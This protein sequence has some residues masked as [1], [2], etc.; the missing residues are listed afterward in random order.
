MSELR[1]NI[2]D[3]IKQWVANNIGGD[4]VFR[5][6][7]LESI[8]NII[9]NVL[10]GSHK[11]H[12][13]EAPTGSGKSLI[14]IIS[15]GVLNKYYDKSS[16]ILCSD[17]YLWKQYDDFI[18]K[19]PELN[20]VIGRLKGQTGNYNCKKNNED[21]RNAECRIAKVPWSKLFNRVTASQYGFDCAKDCLY[22]KAREK[23][24]KSNITLMTYQLYLY[25]I[26]IVQQ[27]ADNPPFK[28]RDVIF[29]DECHNIPSIISAQYTPT[30]SE[31]LLEKFEELYK[32]NQIQFEGLFSD[33][34]RVDNL[35]SFWPSIDHLRDDF[36]NRFSQMLQNTTNEE[37]F[38]LII[39]YIKDF[40]SA[41][42]PTV[43][44]IEDN[45]RITHARMGL[46][47]D[48]MKLYKIAS[49]YRNY[50]CFCSDFSDAIYYCG[51]EYIVKII[52]EKRKSITGEI[53]NVINFKCAKEDYMCYIYLMGSAQNQVLTSA[54][55]GMP[56]SFLDNIGM[57]FMN[58]PEP[59]IDK[60]P[61]T[62]DFSQ[63]PIIYFPKYKM[64]FRYKDEAFPK[65]R[66][67]TYGI[68][69]K[70]SG[71][72]G[73]IQTGSYDNALKV[74]QNAPEDIKKRLLV[75]NNSSEKSDVID[76]H[77]L[78]NDTV[79]I[80]PSLNEGIDLPDDMCRFIVIMKVPYPSLTDELVKAKMEIFPYWYNSE[81][82]NHIIQGIGR[83]NRHTND[84][85]I[86]YI[87]DG[88]F[89][90]LYKATNEQYSKEL[91]NRIRT[92]I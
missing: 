87:L 69:R 79:L 71:L 9:D 52:E 36:N 23:A 34:A 63:S 5:E 28:D 78:S 14:L 13:I 1:Q 66:E 77:K 11:T 72:R 74:Y 85:C 21:I 10:N 38:D 73:I 70:H 43:A 92:L 57:K 56:E 19:Y 35:S 90:T 6:Y 50:C 86:T 16:Y 62:F 76:F 15:A 64:S 29:C 48:I 88:C 59:R 91:Q 18:N 80:G 22:V 25:M 2:E 53:Y 3:N 32:Y 27:N 81:T 24:Q 84:W 39:S 17:L 54:T 83:G 55:I 42:G 37:S 20:K 12:I 45:V 65:L 60:I 44:L 68:I 75:Y 33:E 82:S 40:V 49:W 26:N 7:Q 47:T 30:I 31:A 89:S 67:I 58:N 41:F 46:T 61:S 4:F 8:V 51:P